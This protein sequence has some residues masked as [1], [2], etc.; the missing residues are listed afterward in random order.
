MQRGGKSS[1]SLTLATV[2]AGIGVDVF[3][4]FRSI[5]GSF[6]SLQLLQLGA[7][8]LAAIVGS[9]VLV[10]QGSVADI[11]VMLAGVDGLATRIGVRRE[12]VGHGVEAESGADKK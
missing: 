7:V 2:V 10:C 5:G 11:A 3:I 1:R 9:S 6:L 4:S 8:L 12:N